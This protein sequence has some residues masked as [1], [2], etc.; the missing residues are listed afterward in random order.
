VTLISV[1]CRRFTSMPT[2]AAHARAG[3]AQGPRKSPLARERSVAWAAPPRTML[4]AQIV[5]RR[6]RLT[7]P[8]IRRRQMMR[9]SAVPSPREEALDHPGSRKVTETCRT[10]NRKFSVLR[11][12]AKTPRRRHGHAGFNDKQ[13]MLVA[14][15]VILTSRARSTSAH[16]LRKVQHEQF[17]RPFAH[18]AGSLP[19]LGVNRSREVE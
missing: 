14:E 7:A 18:A 6:T 3:R 12:T 8:E 10:A 15:R 11:H 1:R 16:Q 17:F 2:K 19:G 9:L 4:G 13:R 5:R